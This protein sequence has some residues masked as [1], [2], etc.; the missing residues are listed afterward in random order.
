ML[1]RIDGTE[2]QADVKPWYQ[3]MMVWLVIALPLIVVVASMVT[4]TIA[5]QNA[6]QLVPVSSE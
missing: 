2:P 6:P 1:S 5:H 4:V 3:Y